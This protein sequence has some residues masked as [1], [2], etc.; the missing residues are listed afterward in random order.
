MGR[1]IEM[2]VYYYLGDLY[3]THMEQHTLDDLQC[4]KYT[5]T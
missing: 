5:V 1:I 3:S 2:F 4:N